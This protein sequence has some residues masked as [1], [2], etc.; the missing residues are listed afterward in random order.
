MLEFVGEQK[1]VL[2][3]QWPSSFCFIYKMFSYTSHILREQSDIS[4]L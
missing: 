4:V 2:I 3:I 1:W